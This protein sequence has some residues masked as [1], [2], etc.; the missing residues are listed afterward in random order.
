MK[1]ILLPTLCLLYSISTNALQLNIKSMDNYESFEAMF[2]LTDPA[3]LSAYAFLDCQS[4]FQ[5]FDF[6]NKDGKIIHEN[7]ITINECEYLFDNIR[8]CLKNHQNKCVS[9]EDIFNQDCNCQQ[10]RN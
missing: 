10:S 4:Y 6:K 1:K 9:S 5:K 2:V 3:K 8:S 7:Y